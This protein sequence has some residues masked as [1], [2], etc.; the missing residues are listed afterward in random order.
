MSCATPIP[1]ETLVAL[2]A[3]ELADADAVEEHLF[4][5]DDCAAAVE[6]LDRVL[7]GMLEMV[8]PVI[9]AELLDRFARRGLKMREIAF[10][11]GDHGEAFFAAEL[12]L[13]IFRLRADLANAQRIDVEIHTPRLQFH[14]HHVP[15]DAARGE[16]LV[17]CQQH[18]QLYQQP[19]DADPEF[20]VYAY[21]DGA[22]RRVA[23]YVIKH[24]WPAL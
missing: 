14:F 22:R 17:A 12:D 4:A 5:C 7:S 11:P 15:F 18:F 2:W 6:Q 13:L 16:V 20:R 9:S 8:P 19:G 24:V 23:S 21:A 10:Q 3:G 1:F